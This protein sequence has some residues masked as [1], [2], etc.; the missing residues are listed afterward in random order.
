MLSELKALLGVKVLTKGEQKNLKGGKPCCD[1]LTQCCNLYCPST[2][3]GQ[4]GFCNC[5]SGCQYCY[6]D[7]QYCGCI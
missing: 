1:P 4:G 2:C 5:T 3:V 6:T 7:Y